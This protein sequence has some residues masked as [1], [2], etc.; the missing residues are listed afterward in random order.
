MSPNSV[1]FRLFTQSDGQCR[2]ICEDTPDCRSVVR[3]DHGDQ[4]TPACK[5]HGLHSRSYQ[6]KET[7]FLDILLQILLLVSDRLQPQ[8][9]VLLLVPKVSVNKYQGP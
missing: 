6:H 8:P 2:A 1:L 4:C 5:G 7:F 3:T 9:S